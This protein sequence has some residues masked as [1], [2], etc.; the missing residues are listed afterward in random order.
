MLRK[1]FFGVDGWCGRLLHL[2][3]AAAERAPV[4]G[5]DK[6]GAEH[7]IDPATAAGTRDN[8]VKQPLRKSGMRDLSEGNRP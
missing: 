7:H 8:A 2:L 5:C 4:T 3:S 1:V 6:L